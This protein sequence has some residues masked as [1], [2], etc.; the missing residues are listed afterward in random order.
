VLYRAAEGAETILENFLPTNGAKKAGQWSV[1]MEN[2]FAEDEAWIGCRGDAEQLDAPETP[3]EL[4]ACG[5][6]AW[7]LPE[8]PA[9]LRR[10]VELKPSARVTKDWEGRE[11]TLFVGGVD[12][13]LR[14]NGA[15]LTPLGKEKEAEIV[16]CLASEPLAETDE[17]LLGLLAG[18]QHFFSQIATFVTPRV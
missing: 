5:Y 4:R 10:L 7:P 2:R 11:T 8:A 9:A 16:T 12:G 3:D 1:S 13:A 6:A 18:F 14:Y 17:A 15:G